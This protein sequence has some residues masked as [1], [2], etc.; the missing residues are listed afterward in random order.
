MNIEPKEKEYVV[1]VDEQDKALGTM[2]KSEVH[3]SNTPLHR[4]FSV[5][6]FN[7]KGEL[8][9]QQR[10]HIKKTWPLIGSNSCCGHPLPEEDYVSA[11]KRRV[12]YELGLELDTVWCL[13]PKFR[14]R[15]ELYGVVEN[16]FCPVFIAFTDEVPS[17]NEEEI[18][19]IKWVPWSEFAVT[20]G[21]AEPSFSPWCIEETELLAKDKQFIHLFNDHTR[22]V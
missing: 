1:L 14:Y 11:V 12:K 7:S 9:L 22:A 5:F 8:L 21:D 17:P 3:T 4:A 13:L 10:S 18:E 2:L 15:A 6:I 20:V 19:A 16:E